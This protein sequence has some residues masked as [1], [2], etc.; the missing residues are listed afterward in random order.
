MISGGL[1]TQRLGTSRE[2][3]GF[4]KWVEIEC[5]KSFL[6][7]TKSEDVSKTVLE[8]ELPVIQNAHYRE[9]PRFCIN[10]VGG[11]TIGLMQDYQS[12]TKYASFE[13]TNGRL[14]GLTQ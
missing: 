8:N 13:T 12:I 6:P 1:G 10:K 5:K 9:A 2:G 7:G 14:D 11:R 3:F 4:G